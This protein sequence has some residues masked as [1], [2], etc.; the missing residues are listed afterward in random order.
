MEF[1]IREMQPNDGEQVLLI[2]GEGIAGGNATFDRDVPSWE[3]WD[4]KFLQCCRLVAEDAN[5]SIAGWA[6][7]QPVSKRDC[8]TGV[9]EVSIY[10]SNR[11]HGQGLG[12]LMLRKLIEES[13]ENGFWTLQAGIF[14]ENKASIKI[15]EKLGFRIVGIREKFGQMN[16]NWR[17]VVLLERRSNTVGK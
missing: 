13:E 17:D 9:A 10:L 11:A 7:I 14:P 16:G 3:A 12:T 6:A 1:N 8:F 2:F 4:S 15:H 5:H